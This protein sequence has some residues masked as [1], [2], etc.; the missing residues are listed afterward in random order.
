[1]AGYRDSRDSISFYQRGAGGLPELRAYI[2]SLPDEVLYAYV[3]F[4]EDKYALLTVIAAHASGVKRARAL[5]HSRPLGQFFK[6]APG[7][8]VSVP[9]SHTCSM[10]LSHTYSRPLTLSLCLSQSDTPSTHTFP[11][12]RHV[13]TTIQSLEDINEEYLLQRMAMSPISPIS[14]PRMQRFQSAI[15]GQQVVAARTGRMKSV[16]SST[17]T[18]NHEERR[19]SPQSS[20]KPE[21]FDA[22]LHDWKKPMPITTAW[23]R[24]TPTADE[25]DSS[26]S[27]NSGNN[28]TTTTADEKTPSVDVET[29]LPTPVDQSTPA[30]Y[31]FGVRAE[32]SSLGRPTASHIL[33]G[34]IGVLDHKNN[35]WKRRPYTIVN[36]QM[37]F[38]TA[39][40]SFR[41]SLL[42]E[43]GGVWEG[44]TS[45]TVSTGTT[46]ANHD[47]RFT[48]G[49]WYFSRSL[50][51]LCRTQSAR[52]FPSE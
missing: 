12:V 25:D 32:V 38:F 37:I 41:F 35:T 52:G 39:M 49:P 24:S 14:Q 6:V 45:L 47:G 10:F 18:G 2:E 13:Q 19:P 28:I 15:N 40:V 23:N 27:P 48:H 44:G 8:S 11:Q 7:R 17:T 4:N 33:H 50:G 16:D 26:A 36:R 1:M 29:K 30:K 42:G 34:H 51:Y 43:G 3:R 46:Q 22:L 20:V 21:D 9:L 5:V 31:A